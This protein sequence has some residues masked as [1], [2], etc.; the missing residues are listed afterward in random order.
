MVAVWDLEASRQR[1]IET[2][3][4][5]PAASLIGALALSEKIEN[6]VVVDIGGTTTEISLFYRGVNPG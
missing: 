5:G 1:P 6:A 2:I 4:S 3:L